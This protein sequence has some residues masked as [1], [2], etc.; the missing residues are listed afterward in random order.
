MSHGCNHPGL[1]GLHL[2]VQRTPVIQTQFARYDADDLLADPLSLLMT[3]G[4]DER[5]LL[6]PQT[7]LNRYFT[8][9]RPEPC[10]SYGSSTANF[11]SAPAMAEVRRRVL[12]IAPGFVL[13]ADGY[14]QGLKALRSRLQRSW[15]IPATVDIVFAAS[16]TDLEYVSLAAAWHDSVM[17]PV[18]G[19]VIGIDNILLGADE[20]G[21]GCILAAQGLHYATMTP[22]G[23]KVEKGNPLHADLAAAIR[24]H[25]LPVRASDGQPVPSEDLLLMI[26]EIVAPS[27]AAGRRPLLHAVHGSKTGLVLPELRH[28]DA[29]RRRYGR[30]ITIV[31]DACQTRISREVVNAYLSRDCIVLLTG[32]KFV[33]GPPF[34]GFALVPP[35]HGEK[36]SL[37]PGLDKIFRRAEFPA[38][39]PQCNELPDEANLGLLLR[40]E[41]SIFEIE[42]FHRLHPTEV[43]R[44]VTLFE[45]Q[46]D[47]FVRR[48]GARRIGPSPAPYGALQQLPIELR[49]LATIDLSAANPAFDFDYARTLYLS[50]ANSDVSKVH[51]LFGLRLGQPVRSMPLDDGRYAGNFRV[52]LSMPQIVEF[53]TMDMSTL[54]R[55]MADDFAQIGA[56]IEHHIN[57]HR[58]G[59]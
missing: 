2:V 3:D 24:L 40:L 14:A 57:T 25:T 36:E 12:E 50:L 47:Q 29:L 11:I 23:L 42:L 5:I 43:L 54:D 33:G 34:S 45:A 10:I 55:R 58:N 13:D 15:N 7:G 19:P 59:H 17:G 51:H 52:G 44:V 9:P 22:A 48:I 31:V 6:D 46:V 4:G 37:P 18:M 27:I 49:T 56:R 38:H 35:G 28:I 26:S 1:S 53:A 41:A 8:S 32:S 39:W 30:A 21:S 16:G 20:V